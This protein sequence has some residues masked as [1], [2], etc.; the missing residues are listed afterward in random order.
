MWGLGVWGVQYGLKQLPPPRKLERLITI[1]SYLERIT[2]ANDDYG[3]GSV[4]CGGVLWV[5]G[6]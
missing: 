5:K 3:R 6:A 4:G 2:S 1:V